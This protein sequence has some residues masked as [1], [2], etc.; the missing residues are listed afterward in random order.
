MD[1]GIKECGGLVD[2]SQGSKIREAGGIYASKIVR[3]RTKEKD[4]HT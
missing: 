3:Q 4:A 1:T 2:S